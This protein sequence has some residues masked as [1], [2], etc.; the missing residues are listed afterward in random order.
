M[1]G[2]VAGDADDRVGAHEPPCLCI[3][4]VLLSDVYAVATCVAGKFGTVVEDEGDLPRLGD[5]AQEIARAPCLVIAGVLEAEL[6]TGD[7]A[8]LERFR[9]QTRKRR[10]VEARRRDQIEPTAS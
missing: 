8:A 5:R 9:K 10:R 2:V 3:G 7:V 1:P 4:R 6:H